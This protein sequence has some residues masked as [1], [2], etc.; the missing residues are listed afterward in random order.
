MSRRGV[1]DAPTPIPYPYAYA[2]FGPSNHQSTY[3]TPRGRIICWG[4]RG[5]RGAEIP[6]P[7][8]ETVTP[9]HLHRSTLTGATAT[10]V[11]ASKCPKEL[12]NPFFTGTG[13]INDTYLLDEI[14]GFNAFL[15][16]RKK[17]VQIAMWHNYDLLLA[18]LAAEGKCIYLTQKH[19]PKVLIECSV[20]KA[21]DWCRG[22]ENHNIV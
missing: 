10:M 16:C 12:I 17:G 20:R 21:F 9:V 19:P 11:Q 18:N 4:L 15:I 22:K 6:L 7:P 1:S 8:P 3:S 2:K 13:W 5:R 14:Y